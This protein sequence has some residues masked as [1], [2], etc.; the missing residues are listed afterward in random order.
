QAGSL[1]AADRLRFDYT[2]F[3]PLTDKERARIETLVNEKIRENIPVSTREMD[4]DTAI[5]EGAV[6]L[7]GEKY[8][9]TVRVVNVPG[10]SKELCGGTHVT[11]TGDIGIFRITSEG[12][13]ASGVRR[14]E[15][16][17]GSNAHATILAEQ[18]SLS[19]M[20]ELLKAPPSEEIS[21]LKKLLSKNRQLE[22]E[23]TTLKEK[24]V[25]GKESAGTDDVRQHG[26]ISYLVK[27]LDDMDSKTLRTFIDNAKN[28]LKSGVVVVGSVSDG[29]VSMAAGVTKDLTDKYHA[30]NII[31]QIAKI[32]GGSGGGRPDMAQ[33]G[34]SEVDKLDE[35]L[36][37]AEELIRS[38]E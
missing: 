10:F 19:A 18:E 20:R 15:A 14:I 13:I 7:F 5:K 21:K 34:G 1:V 29:K 16:V 25:S 33:A 28:Q 31:K 22:K 11:A 24:M 23:I 30:G 27:K 6:A 2:H 3:S 4:I 9:D 17:T 8:G 35:A 12:G 36:N 37:K 32:V 38:T 26:N